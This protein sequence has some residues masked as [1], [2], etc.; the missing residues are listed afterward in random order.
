M[1]IQELEI[2]TGMDR[3]TI[4]FYEKEGLVVPERQANGYRSYSACDFQLLMKIKLLRQLG[5][6]LTS[7][8]ELQQGSAEFSAVLAEQI[9]FLEQRIQQDNRAKTICQEMQ[10]NGVE[11]QSL[12][13]SYYLKRLQSSETGQEKPYQEELEVEVHP[14]RRYIARLLDKLLVVAIMEFIFVVLFRIRPFSDILF[15]VVQYLAYFTAVP[16]EAVLLHYFGTTPGKLV[17][18]IRIEN[19]NGG[20]LDFWSALYRSF[21]VLKDGCGFYIPGWELWKLYKSYN[22]ASVGVRNLWDEDSE[23]IYTDWKPVQKVAVGMLV[24]IITVLFWV[25]I[26]DVIMP[27]NRKEN[28]TLKEFVENFRDYEKMFEFENTYYLTQEG[29]WEKNAGDG[30]EI[31]IHGD[32]E[33]VRKPFEYTYQNG[34]LQSVRFQDEW[35]D[36][37]FMDLIPSYCI[38]AMYAVVGSRPDV[39]YHNLSQMEEMLNTNFYDELIGK[40]QEG[41]YSD[42]FQI[43]DVRFSFNAVIEGEAFVSTDGMLVPVDDSIVSYRFDFLLEII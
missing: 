15:T 32:L 34:Y 39:T 3:A 33:H 21:G 38:S 20:K 28:I 14:V 24:G 40:S 25:N 1:Q 7:I 23:I 31:I 41:I 2:R 30:V 8:K 11:F 12:D 26:T 9:K 18:G 16:I 19:V 4:R 6:S 17:M 43:A 37:G 22:T 10:E 35:D 29:S 5:V 27:S 36:A 42:S 13:S